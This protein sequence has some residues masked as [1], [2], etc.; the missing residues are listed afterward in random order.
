[1]AMSLQ[2]TSVLRSR[3]Y[4]LQIDQNPQDMQLY[5][6]IR[7]EF[8]KANEGYTLNAYRDTT[9]HVTVGIGFNMD[10][11][12]AQQVWDRIFSSNLSF[13]RVY[14]SNDELSDEDVRNLFQYSIQQRL[15]QLKRIYAQSWLKLR[16]NERLGIEDSY[17][18]CPALVNNQTRFYQYINQYV[19]TREMDY[20][21]Q[22]INEIK[23]DSNP[24]DN[25][26]IQNRRNVEAEM[27]SAPVS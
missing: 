11:A 7:Y 22:A 13:N 23:N 26:G 2:E 25:S 18:N 10:A 9:G 3:L 19:N 17:Y 1:M 4:P 16:A 12:G 5:Q 27:L 14:N 24:S 21:E 20:L 6:T 15:D 8:I